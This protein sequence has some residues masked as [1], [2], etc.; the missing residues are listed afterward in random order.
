[1]NDPNRYLQKGLWRRLRLPRM[2]WPETWKNLSKEVSP[3]SSNVDARLTQFIADLTGE[4]AGQQP[5]FHSPFGSVFDP[6]YINFIIVFFLIGIYFIFDG[7]HTSGL[8]KD[9]ENTT[10]NCRNLTGKILISEDRPY[11]LLHGEKF[12]L[13]G[14]HS[15]TIDKNALLSVHYRADDKDLT[16]DIRSGSLYYTSDIGPV[17]SMDGPGHRRPDIVFLIDEMKFRPTGTAFQIKHIKN[18][19]SLKMIRGSVNVTLNN[20]ITHDVSAGYGLQGEVG[21]EPDPVIKPLKQNEIRQLMRIDEN[22]R[23]SIQRYIKEIKDPHYPGTE[24]IQ[25]ENRRYG[26]E[27]LNFN[28]KTL[29]IIKLKNGDLIRGALRGELDRFV[30]LTEKGKYRTVRSSEIESIERPTGV[31]TKTDESSNQ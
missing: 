12:L 26:F 3:L 16:V 15:L 29:R 2:F 13:C 1:M 5:V 11:V 6:A 20:R 17:E 10:L 19:F 25:N 21:G 23:K 31:E 27:G 18:K 22:S 8:W 4:D 24:P 14:S 28:N 9:T 30:I 7:F